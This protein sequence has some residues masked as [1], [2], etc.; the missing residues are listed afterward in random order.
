MMMGVTMRMGIMMGVTMRM[1]N[2]YYDG[3]RIRMDVMMGVLL[4]G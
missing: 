2:G 1:G 4:D 3:W